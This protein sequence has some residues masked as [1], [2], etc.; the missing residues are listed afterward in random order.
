MMRRTSRRIHRLMSHRNI[1][2]C[3]LTTQT[4]RPARRKVRFQNELSVNRR[5]GSL[6]SLVRLPSRTAKICQRLS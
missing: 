3:Y 2:E 6:H 5:V 1:A 4:E